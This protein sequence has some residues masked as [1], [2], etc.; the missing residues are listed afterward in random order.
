MVDLGDS[1]VSSVDSHDSL[2][3]FCAVSSFIATMRDG[4]GLYYRCEMY[5]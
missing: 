1:E 2:E 4:W 3:E 5:N